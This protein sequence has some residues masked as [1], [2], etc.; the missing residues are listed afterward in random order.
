[1]SAR[2]KLLLVGVVAV[3]AAASASC[4]DPVRDAA[5]AEL[6]PED[7]NVPPGPDHRPGQPCLLCHSE[8][9]VASD[10]PMAV[11]GT[12]YTD[13]DG[14]KGLAD[15]EVSFVDARNGGPIEKIVTSDSGNFFVPVAKWSPPG[16]S[17]PF[18]VAIVKDGKVLQAM[19]STVNREGSCNYCHRPPDA[20][21]SL[22]D[23]ERKRRFTLPVY[24]GSP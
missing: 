24:A 3:A 21:S 7:P 20:P 2:P 12:V 14:K 19:A 17:Y 15:V 5:V 8:N 18:R 23:E 4:T 11:A 22:T 16:L 6:G 9:G 1:M 10:S 13:K